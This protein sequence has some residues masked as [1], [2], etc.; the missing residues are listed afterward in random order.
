MEDGETRKTTIRHIYKK[1][2]NQYSQQDIEAKLAEKEATLE[3]K[4]Q[5]LCRLQQLLD[6]KEKQLQQLQ[7]NMKLNH[8]PPEQKESSLQKRQNYSKRINV[9]VDINSF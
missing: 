6:E 9:C 8:F 7:L 1:F 4:D 5:Q 2:V 3:Q